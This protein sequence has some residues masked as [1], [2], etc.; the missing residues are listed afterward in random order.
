MAMIHN[1]QRK[2]MSKIYSFPSEILLN[3][4][5]IIAVAVFSILPIE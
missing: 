1:H 5:I 4:S 2:G 3:D